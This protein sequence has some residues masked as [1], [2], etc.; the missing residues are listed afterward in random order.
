MLKLDQKLISFINDHYEVEGDLKFIEGGYQNQ[1][2]EVVNQEVIF[3]VSKVEKRG[4]AATEAELTYIKHLANHHITVAEPI[5][6]RAGKVIE[7]FDKNYLV[8]AFTRAKGSQIA[9]PRYLEDQD[10]YYQL[11]E[12]TGRMHQLSDL[13]LARHHWYD[14]DY[15]RRAKDFIDDKDKLE[16]INHQVEKIRTFVDKPG[17][18]GLIHGDINVGNFFV[19]DNITLIDFDECQ[20]S[21]FVED[22]AI[23]LFYTVYVFGDDN[24]DQ[25]KNKGIDFMKAFLKGYTKH[26]ALSVEELKMIPE[27]LILREMIVHVGIYKMWDLENLDEWSSGYFADASKRILNKE[28]I[29][30]YTLDWHEGLNLPSTLE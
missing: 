22:I 1:V 10:L 21:W 18:Y 26:K 15:L 12:L 27:F 2:I 29:I 17:A 8:V 20:Y 19:G 7:V 14:N 28:A 30:S 3:R 16:A 6:S 11:G 23:Q 25:R 4:L 9:Y 13:K 5:L 24:K